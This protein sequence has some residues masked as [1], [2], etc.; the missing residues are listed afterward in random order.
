[1]I[2]G[3]TVTFAAM[4]NHILPKSSN[5]SCCLQARSLLVA[6]GELCAAQDRLQSETKSFSL[7]QKKESLVH[8]LGRP[9]RQDQE[10]LSAA[11]SKW[12]RFT[13]FEMDEEARL[14][15]ENEEIS[16]LTQQLQA[17]NQTLGQLEESR[18]TLMARE[19]MLLESQRTLEAEL[20]TSKESE[21][22]LRREL[23]LLEKAKLALHQ[24]L[25]ELE[26]E[27]DALQEKLASAKMVAPSTT[28]NGDTPSTAHNGDRLYL[29]VEERM[30]RMQTLVAER[31]AELQEKEASIVD[32]EK[33]LKRKERQLSSALEDAA[34]QVQE[35]ANAL[36]QKEIDLE[37][38]ETH[39][40]SE[41][42]KCK[43][44]QSRLHKLAFSVQ[45]KARQLSND[46]A[47]LKRRRKECDELEKGLAEWQ[48]SLE[49]CKSNGV[50]KK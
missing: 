1:M 5:S 28:H 35:K 8:I 19:Q 33:A 40:A 4:V 7:A 24:S 21:S 48:Q 31:Q 26:Q 32:R 44:T 27:K 17:V 39:L 23:S 6:Q 50:A 2:R 29:G 16:D 37:F 18:A 3:V 41:L 25:R 20:E 22:N 36:R 12:V 15:V 47:D 11:F 49:S 13:L 46:Q 9:L 30:Q 10:R 43:D 38:K 34:A 45:E 14:L 42:A